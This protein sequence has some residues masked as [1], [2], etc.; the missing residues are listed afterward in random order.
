MIDRER[1]GAAEPELKIVE[2]ATCTFCGCVCDDIELHVQGDRIVEAKRAC[3]LGTAWFLNHHVEDRPACLI[4]GKPASVE[5]GIHEAA[6]ILAE[7]KYPLVYGLSDTTVEAQRVAASLADWLGA[8][9]DTTTSV[10]HGPSGMAFQ[11]VGE[12]TCS[13]GEVR[14][15]GDLIIFWGSNPAESH[16]R[17]FTKYSLMPKGLFVPNG[18]RDRTCV[19]VDVRKTKSAKAAD[20][21][22]QIKPRADFEALWTLRALAKGLELDARQVEQDTGQPLAVWQDLV[23]RMKRARFGVIFFG[24]GLTM[25]RGKH[26]NSEALLALTRDL[27]RH[28]RFVCKPNRGHGNVTG[29]DNVVSWRTGFPFGV[30]LARGYPRFNPGE[31]T[32]ADVLARG[33]A[34]AALILASDPMANFSQPA[35]EHLK[36]IPYVALDPKETPTTRHATVAFTVATYGINVPGTVYRM[37]DVPIPLRPAF[38]SPFP[39]DQEILEGIERLV[40]QW[41]YP[42]PQPGLSLRPAAAG[43]LHR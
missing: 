31:Y 36:R 9:L 17:H 38:P 21:F 32:A 8:C 14:N 34:D 2:D 24:M 41:K 18:R 11:G 1:S 4:R 5:E 37:D 39:S 3:V 20:I 42:R 23:E 35:R 43:S 6:R 15:R 10:C 13:L 26:A 33:E 25:T 22:I 40:R 28:T 7:A 30:N 16:P 27:N 19:V 29:A 12:V